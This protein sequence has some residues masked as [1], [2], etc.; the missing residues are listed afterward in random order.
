MEFDKSKWN[1]RIDGFYKYREN[2]VQDLMEVHLK[3]GMELKNVIDLL[4]KPENY[5]N[6]KSN[7]IIYEIMVDYGW[8]IDP[9]EGKELHFEFDKDSTVTD[10]RLKHWEH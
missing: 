3:T 10:I 9:I 7:E 2:M 1:E 6:K 5:H 4:G 8:N